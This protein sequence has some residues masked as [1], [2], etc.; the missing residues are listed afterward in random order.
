MNGT[1]AA[2][3]RAWLNFATIDAR[4]AELGATTEDERGKL[5]G[6]GR[7]SLWRWR[8]QTTDVGIDRAAKIA[9]RLGLALDDIILADAS[10]PTPRP[11][12]PNPNPR[13]PSGPD[14]GSPPSGPP[15][16]GGS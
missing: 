16:K 3:R 7:V 2:Q 12:P 1:T 11:T 13:P 6:T 8:N 10:R 4:C 9:E 14:T 15:R 5:L